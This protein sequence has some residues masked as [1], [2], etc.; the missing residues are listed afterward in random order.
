[1]KKLIMCQGLPGSGK[2]TWAETERLTAFHRWHGTPEELVVVTVNK[3]R[4]RRAFELTTNWHWSREREKDVVQKRDDDIL[5]AFAAH[6]NVIVISDDTNLAREHRKRLRELATISGAAFEVKRFDVP[7]EECIRRARARTTQPQVPE[8][9]IRDMAA[10]YGWGSPLTYP[11]AVPVPYD[12][13]ATGLRLAP[14]LICNLDG[15]L[16]LLNGRD[17]YKP[18]SCIDDLCNAPVR[19]LLE[20]YYRTQMVNIIYL[21]GREDTYRPQTETF[22]RR[23]HCPPG[24]LH[25]RKAGDHRKDWVV[26]GELFDA[27]VRGRYDV[28]FVLDDRDQVVNYWRHLGLTC[29]QV[30]KGDF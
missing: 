12:D 15:T 29:F 18:S 23:H 17:P 27:H 20:I 26:K 11:E 10:R 28:K 7:L 8:T 3:D 14:A 16:C 9:A 2:S 13:P 4:I 5:K 21:S 6:T 24:A 1:M 30:A 22:F 25:M 19:T